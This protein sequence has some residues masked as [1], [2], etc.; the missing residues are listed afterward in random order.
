MKSKEKDMKWSERSNSEKL[1]HIRD[2][3]FKALEVLEDA[4]DEM[5]WLTLEHVVA[6]RYNGDFC[7][8]VIDIQE[9]IMIDLEDDIIEFIDNENMDV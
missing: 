4:K 3:L 8:A 1:E 7:M 9:R 5:K 6:S 2:D